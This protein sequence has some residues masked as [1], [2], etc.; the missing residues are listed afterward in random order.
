MSQ[1]NI[2]LTE[3]ELCLVN[4]CAARLRVIQGDAIA[5]DADK[6]C[7]YLNEEVN[8]SFKVLSPARRRG[9]LEALLARFPVAGQL[10]KAASP[11]APLPAAP[12]TQTPEQLV[13]RLIATAAEIPEDQRTEFA[14][15][16]YD[17]GLRWVD[18]GALELE[19]SKELQTRFG[20][21]A[22]RQPRLERVVKLASL[23]VN[24]LYELDRTAMIALKDLYPRSAVLNRSQDFRQATGQYLAGN[25]DEIE[26]QLRAS[27][28][29][30]GGMLAALLGGGRDFGRQFIE[31][32]S[33]NSIEEVVFSEGSKGFMGPSKKE[34]CW[35]KYCSLSKDIATPEQLDRW[36]KDCLGRFADA[37]NK[38]AR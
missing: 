9:C 13:E 23:M 37:G 4:D 2:V 24:A 29:L 34:R 18:H 11:P 27:S 31:K 16:L 21:P 8:R 7:E 1:A 5:I 14:R 30:L 10:V 12:V 20:L 28:A 25:T 15:R 36:V 19:I 22:D 38:G 17:A 3:E 26:P 6:R 33:P 35:D 32:Y